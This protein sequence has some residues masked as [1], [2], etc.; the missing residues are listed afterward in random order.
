MALVKVS[1]TLGEILLRRREA[2]PQCAPKT[3]PGPLVRPVKLVLFLLL[4]IVSAG[5]F[6]DVDPEL[7]MKTSGWAIRGSGLT[8][9]SFRFGKF[10][11]VDYTL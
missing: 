11:C 8:I 9:D 5:Y 1:Q 10:T 2:S 4:V 7:F 3:P 6:G